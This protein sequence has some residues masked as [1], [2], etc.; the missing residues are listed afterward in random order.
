IR[1]V[2]FGSWINLLLVAV[3]VGFVVNYLDI[4][5]VAIFVV[6]FIAI[7]PLAAMLSYAT[8]EIALRV[9]KTLGR[10]LNATF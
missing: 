9:S 2:L 3:P 5:G 8:K 10:L 6:N 4:N 1:A 7:V